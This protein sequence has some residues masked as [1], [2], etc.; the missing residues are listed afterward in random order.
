MMTSCREINYIGL[1]PTFTD[2][3]LIEKDAH[4]AHPYK[5]AVFSGNNSDVVAKIVQPR[6]FSR[7]QIQEDDSIANMSF[8]WKPTQ[9][10]SKVTC[11]LKTTLCSSIIDWTKSI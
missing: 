8:V 7:L 9:F 5:C 6:G 1:H 2:F 11:F 4:S 10:T 3:A